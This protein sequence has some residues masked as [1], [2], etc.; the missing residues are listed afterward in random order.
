MNTLV[1]KRHIEREPNT[2]WFKIDKE[3]SRH[4]YHQFTERDYSDLQG[5]SSGSQYEL[6]EEQDRAAEQAMNYFIKNGR[7]VVNFYGMQSHALEK[8]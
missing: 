3:L 1:N 4:Y 7:R 6:R 8:H 2:E 5:K